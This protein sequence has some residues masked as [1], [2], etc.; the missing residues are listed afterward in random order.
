M[1]IQIPQIIFQAIN[2]FVIVYV[3]H[4]FIYKPILNILDERSKKV[5]AGLKAAENNLKQEAEI[6]KRV[7][8]EIKQARKEAKEILKDAKIEAEKKAQEIIQAATIKA[9]K[10]LEK[11]RQSLA[12]QAETEKAKMKDEF[13]DMVVTATR[14]VLKNSLGQSEQ[15]RIVES[16]IKKI[17]GYTIA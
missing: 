10:A 13:A 16:Q 2:F 6:E 14:M 15:Q 5:E 3:L 11:E 1:D 17:K 8:S 4:R 9:K 12:T 7:Q